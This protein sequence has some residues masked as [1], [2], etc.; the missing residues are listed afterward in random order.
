MKKRKNYPTSI[1]GAKRR[2]Y[3]I[4][5]V[6]IGNMEKFNTSWLGLVIWTDRCSSK[7]FINN[8][9]ERKMAFEAEEDASMFMLKWC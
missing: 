3:T 2:G 9:A 6:P 8:F 7:H 4:V 1:R 5:D